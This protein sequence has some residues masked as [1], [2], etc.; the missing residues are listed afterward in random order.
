LSTALKGTFVLDFTTLLPGPLAT[1][2]MAQAGARVVKIERPGGDELRSYAPRYGEDSAYFA[3]LNHG[4]E[5]L[6]ADLKD[7]LGLERVRELA[8]ECDVLVE[9]FRPGVMDRLGLGYEAVSATNA[10]VIYCSI[11]GYGQQGPLA[12]VAGHDLNYMA[13]A[14][15]LSL[16]SEPALPPVLIADLAGAAQP[17]VI[18]MLLALVRRERTGQGA[19]I[20]VS[21]ARNLFNL[22]PYQI[23]RGFLSGEWPQPAD[24]LVTGGSPRYNVYWAADGR[25]VAVAAIEDRFWARFCALAELPEDSTREMVAEHLARHPAQYWADLLEG[26]D[27]CVNVVRTLAEAVAHPQFASLFDEP[28]AEGAPIPRLPLPSGGRVSAGRR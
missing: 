4:K 24:D 20:D 22:I 16:T 25:S 3:V 10:A 28:I 8:R 19:R 6:T 26:E 21:M 14:G 27:T 23:A 2:L 12:A 15:L 5:C 1:Q 7:P 9:Q 18:E 17:A 13:A 11:S